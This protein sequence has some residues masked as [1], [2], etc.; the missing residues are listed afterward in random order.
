LSNSKVKLKQVL[1][2]SKFQTEIPI[3]TSLC[4]FNTF[5]RTSPALVEAAM[6]LVAGSSGGVAGRG[7]SRVRL[8]FS[9][10]LQ[11][12]LGLRSPRLRTVTPSATYT[13]DE[14]DE[15]STADG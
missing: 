11:R 7:R 15:K 5:T 3:T 2:G 8:V 14:D 9:D 10:L 12:L 1:V 6:A 4:H 13:S